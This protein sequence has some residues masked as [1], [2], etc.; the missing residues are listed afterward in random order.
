MLNDIE[1]VAIV[2]I[3][4]VNILC[5]SVCGHQVF[6]N[7]DGHFYTATKYAVT[8]LTEGL[9][10]ELRAENTHIRATVSF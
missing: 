7:A 4:L 9:R 2:V 8:A 1:T 10:K 6:P 5:C 3:T